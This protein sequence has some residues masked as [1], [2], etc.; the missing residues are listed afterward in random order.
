MDLNA[1]KGR[2]KLKIR[3]SD[4]RTTKVTADGR[5]LPVPCD[6]ILYL[7]ISYLLV[8]SQRLSMKSEVHLW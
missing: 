1:L 2:K 3:F 7:T 4:R 8:D 6:I 5:R